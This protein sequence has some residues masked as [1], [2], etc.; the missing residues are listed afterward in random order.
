MVEQEQE[1]RV[2]RDR[3]VERALPAA[4]SGE[5]GRRGR[6][7]PWI[8]L[9]VSL[10]A[11]YACARFFLAR[12]AS[13]SKRF[14]HGDADAADE[15]GVPR[16]PVLRGTL[17][18]EDGVRLEVLVAPVHAV[19]DLEAFRSESLRKHL[20]LP[21]GELFRFQVIRAERSSASD[22]K[23]AE[24]SSASPEENGGASVAFAAPAVHDARGAAIVE[25]DTLLGESVR[26]DPW[27]HLLGM[28]SRTSDSYVAL[29][30]GRFPD[31]K[32]GEQ[33]GE[34][35]L[36]LQDGE[37]TLSVPLERR[38]VVRA[39]SEWLAR[40]DARSARD[41][42]EQGRV[43][44]RMAR[45]EQELE[46]E[47]ARRADRELEWLEFQRSLASLELETLRPI[48]NSGE[49][50]TN[51]ATADE[52]PEVDPELA[53]ARA[54]TEEIERSLKTLFKLE[55][56]RG[57]DVLEMGSLGD[58]WVGPVAFR[59]LDDRGRLVGGLFAERLRLEASRSARTVAVVL[60]DG[61]ETE[62]EERRPF[63]EGM[64][65]IPLSHIDPQPW[66]EALPELFA[67]DVLDPPNDDGLWDH[68]KLRAELNRLL[69]LDASAGFLRVHSFGGVMQDLIADVHL[70]QFDAEGHLERRLFADRL[71]IV[72]DPQG[73][74]LV[75]EGGAF[76][77]GDSKEPFR[78]GEHRIFL[79]RA[80]YSEWRAAALP[81]LVS[82]NR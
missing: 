47:R 23:G 29:G 31:E 5:R 6:S 17:E 27:T 53:R 76:V 44:E 43:E 3:E 82:S 57:L 80:P 64:R 30:W 14:V 28:D 72:V 55:G 21:E 58:G 71:R 66:L 63:V 1:G 62:G 45:L 41:P 16:T 54:R 40:I 38:E 46:A 11:S 35:R 8:L 42:D 22:A 52:A 20:G 9:A 39:E 65:R 4:A 49:E 50:S 59:L 56:L 19:R 37:H 10:V 77:V 78:N 13:S 74:W 75:L 73:S 26:G 25:I 61:F 48:L 69:G 68:G 60:E 18:C 7:S 67:S 34:V 24:R 15:R 51:S 81:G 2:E 12:P 32:G 36:E 70:E 33:G 79:T